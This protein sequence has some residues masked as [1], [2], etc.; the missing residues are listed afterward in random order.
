MNSKPSLDKTS[1]ESP[2]ELAA[3][4]SSSKM[5]LFPRKRFDRP[6]PEKDNSLLVWQPPSLLC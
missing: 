4:A 1:I 3:R 5:K 2:R 6:R